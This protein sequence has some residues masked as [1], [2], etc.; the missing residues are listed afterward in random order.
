MK[1]QLEINGT[2]YPIDTILYLQFQNSRYL[3]N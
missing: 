2:V 3:Q 1:T